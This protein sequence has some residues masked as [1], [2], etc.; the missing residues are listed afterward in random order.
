[1]G[2]FPLWLERDCQNKR[3]GL[4][5]YAGNPVICLIELRWLDYKTVDLLGQ[6]KIELQ[7]FKNL[8]ALGQ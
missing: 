8:A 1:M 6:I 7:G 4:S 3:M 2:G 5:A